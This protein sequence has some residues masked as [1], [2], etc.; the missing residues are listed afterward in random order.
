MGGEESGERG[1]GCEG[2][3]REG[4]GEES[5]GKGREREMSPLVSFARS[6][7][8][9]KRRLIRLDDPRHR[10]GVSLPKRVRSGRV[11]TCGRVTSPW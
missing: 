4:E 9:D 1:G 8:G 7:H 3:R 10:Y 6:F 5:A 2:G 11:I